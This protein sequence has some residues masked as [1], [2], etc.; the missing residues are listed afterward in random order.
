[1]REKS[2][3][4]R[5]DEVFQIV[6][7]VVALSFDILWTSGRIP[8]A[9]IAVFIFTLSIWAYGNLKGGTVEYP[10]KIGSFNLALMLLTNFYVI[11]IYGDLALVGVLE[12]V[13]GAIILPVACLFISLL[14]ASYM[15]D[16]LDRSTTHGIL[17]GGTIG[18][19]MSINLLLIFV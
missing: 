9:E 3:E 2:R 18:Y 17:F 1:M 14:L 13:V 15:K 8:I 16:T 5:F 7:I 12:R 10:F 6:L 11:S 4:E 19:M